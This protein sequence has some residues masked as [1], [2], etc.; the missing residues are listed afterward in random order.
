MA[1]IPNMCTCEIQSQ[2]GKTT[3][4]EV[5]GRQ[6][7]GAAKAKEYTELETQWNMKNDECETKKRAILDTMCGIK[8]VRL[9]IFKL[10]EQQQL[11]A[12]ACVP[13]P[14]ALQNFESFEFRISFRIN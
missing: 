7:E 14:P 1:S 8:V 13:T 10:A 3:Q 6:A 5:C 4:T 9:E 12:A 11:C 2:S